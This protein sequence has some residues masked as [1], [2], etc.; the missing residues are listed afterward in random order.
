MRIKLWT[1]AGLSMLLGVLGVSTS[2]T[3]AAQEQGK[4]FAVT[5]PID[6]TNFTYTP[7]TIPAGK[8]LEIDYVSMSG[9]A[10]SP[11]GGIQPI[12]ILNATIGADPA[13]LYYLAPPQSGTMPGQFYDSKQTY[14]V[15]DTLSVGPGF[16]G[17]TPSFLSFNVVI[18]GRLFPK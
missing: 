1:L 13:N 7:V 5:V 3:A 11:G 6:I 15:A 18:S 12:I 10:Q 8:R 4:P 17:Y 2:Q 9:A 16:A 14:I